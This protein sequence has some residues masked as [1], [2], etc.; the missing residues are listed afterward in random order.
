MGNVRFRRSGNIS[1]SGVRLRRV[2]AL[3]WTEILPIEK[4]LEDVVGTVGSVERAVSFGNPQSI[5][6][7]SILGI[8][9]V[10]NKR[11]T[12]QTTL[13]S[14]L[15]NKRSVIIDGPLFKSPRG[16]PTYDTFASLP[17]EIQSLITLGAWVPSMDKGGDIN[18]KIEDL[19]IDNI[20]EIRIGIADARP[21]AQ[22]QPQKITINPGDVTFDAINSNKL[23]TICVGR[24][25]S[26][27]KS[28][29]IRL[30]NLFNPPGISF[31][32][33]RKLGYSPRSVL[34][35]HLAA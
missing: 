16:S 34:S 1:G 12:L 19:E 25:I 14:F 9:F 23:G 11:S 17:A 7:L 24:F 2:L 35:V 27:E 29:D 32:I 13:S 28:L 30:T 4:S 21:A 33:I 26:P 10:H 5:G 6:G 18:L 31:L 3:E 15:E 22:D 20:Y 8:D